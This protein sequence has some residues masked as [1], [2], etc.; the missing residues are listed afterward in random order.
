MNAGWG[1]VHGVLPLGNCW[2]RAIHGDF[3]MGARNSRNFVPL[4]HLSSPSLMTEHRAWE[5]HQ[6]WLPIATKS[7]PRRCRR[8]SSPVRLDGRGLPGLLQSSLGCCEAR[9]ENPHERT[10]IYQRR[11]GFSQFSLSFKW[12]SGRCMISTRRPQQV[13]GVGLDRSGVRLERRKVDRFERRKVDRAERRKVT[14]TDT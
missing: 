12:G 10:C 9:L 2:G 13:L 7:H 5:S 1:H 3:L 8:Q 14:R 4:G 6:F 11:P